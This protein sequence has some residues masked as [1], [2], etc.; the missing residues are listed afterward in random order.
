MF[1]SSNGSK[2]P[3]QQVSEESISLRKEKADHSLFHGRK[4]Y[5][6]VGYTPPPAADIRA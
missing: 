3:V 5:R 6:L 2:K 4:W 1:S